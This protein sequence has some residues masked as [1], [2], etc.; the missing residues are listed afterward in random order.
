MYTAVKTFVP[1]VRPSF[2]PSFIIINRYACSCT[3]DTAVVLLS[4]LPVLCVLFVCTSLQHNSRS[5]YHSSCSS[6]GSR[7][8]V[9]L[10]LN[11]LRKV[12]ECEFGRCV[13]VTADSEGMRILYGR[14]GWS[15]LNVCVHSIMSSESWR[16]I[17]NVNQ[18]VRNWRRML[19]RQRQQRRRALKKL[20]VVRDNEQNKK[21]R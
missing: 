9:A 8:G 19:L 12:I 14:A 3:W 15:H 13:G 20:W 16:K 21:E 6:S 10:V 2:H 11:L 1:C 7:N 4:A 17:P 5:I 18:V